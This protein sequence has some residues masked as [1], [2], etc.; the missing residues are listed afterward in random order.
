MAGKSESTIRGEEFATSFLY[1][2][3]IWEG[4]EYID[5]TKAIVTGYHSIKYTNEVIIEDVVTEETKT[6]QLH[7]YQLV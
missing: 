5:V 1:N 7:L 4:L 3:S 2:I 6:K